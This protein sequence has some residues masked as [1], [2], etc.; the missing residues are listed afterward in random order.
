MTNRIAVYLGAFLIGMILLDILVF[1][2]EHI[3]FLTKKLLELIEW[4][5]FWR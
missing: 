4:M 2:T 5:A 3:V 1:G